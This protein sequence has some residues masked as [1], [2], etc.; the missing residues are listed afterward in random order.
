MV[1][2][3]AL[4]SAIAYGFSDFVGGLL[5]RRT[6]VWAVATVGQTVAT[7]GTSAFALL[8]GG[9]PAPGDWLGGGVA[10]V[11]SGLGTVFLYR[12]LSSGR[13]SVV[14]P[15]SAVGAALLPIVVGLVAGERPQL[16]TWL[17]VGCA[18]PAIW[19]V[20]RS[21]APATPAAESA[22][23]TDGLLAGV[24][25]GALFAALG[26]VPEESG[27]WPLTLAQGASVVVIV[28]LGVALRQSWLPRDRDAALGAVPGVLGALATVLFLLSSQAGLLAVAAV[29][30][31]FYP[32]TTVLLAALVLHE[33][34]GHSQA[35]GLL[36]AAAAVAL[37]AVP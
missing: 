34:I 23:V 14:A 19:L 25:F 24:G 4:G 30:A 37:V 9:D 27:L 13:M 35:L 16:L 28:T 7:V 22:G 33:R 29:L 31:S 36:L 21:A 2:L 3:L 1:V 20:S 10:G 18:L 11:G 15:I 5:S 8:V 32:A 26:Q 17:G 12:G 6:S